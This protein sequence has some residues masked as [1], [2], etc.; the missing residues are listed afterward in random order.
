MADASE[1]EALEGKG[2]AGFK[3]GHE[4]AEV[5]AFGVLLQGFLILPGLDDFDMVV[6]RKAGEGFVAYAAIVVEG[7]LDKFY[8]FGACGSCF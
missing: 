7:E 5:L 1:A 3:L 8:G 4:A 6:G 2:A